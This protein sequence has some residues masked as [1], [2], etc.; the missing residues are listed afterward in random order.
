MKVMIAVTHLLGSGHLSRALTL[1]RAF[2]DAGHAA[3]V[4]SGGMP[5]PQLDVRG[6]DFVQLPPLR[7]DGTDFARLLD[8]AGKPAGTGHFLARREALLAALDPVPDVVITELFPFGRRSLSDEFLA[9]LDAAG[10]LRPR[11]VILSSVRDILAPPSTQ[12][13]AAGTEELILS[14]Y[15]AVLVHSDPDATRL[16]ASWPVSPAL[17]RRL[18][19]TGYVAPA[20]AGPHPDGT[21]RDEVIVS[22]GGGPVGLPVFRAAIG[23]ARLMP[24]RRWRLLVGGG[25]ARNQLD[26]LQDLSPPGNAILEPARPDFRNMLHHAAASVSMCGY[27]TAL[28]VLQAGPPAVFVPF[29]A[30]KEV[31]QGLRARSLA[32]LPGIQVLPTAELSPRTLAKAVA[33]V[34]ETPRRTSLTMKFDGAA[35][36]VEIAVALAEARP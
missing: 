2:S 26:R 15:D 5:A 8:E 31:E 3:R 12:K 4:A 11:P 29:D 21:G 1:A 30:G 27:N 20:P 9:L 33:G 18:R 22:A 16:D 14:R 19:Y 25:D 17:E 10:D 28:D 23:A 32:V 6:V 7:S 13:K 35:R 24:D 36:S 34:V